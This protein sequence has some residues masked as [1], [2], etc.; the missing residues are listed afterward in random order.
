MKEI[1]FHSVQRATDDIDSS[2]ELFRV[3]SALVFS[4][5]KDIDIP[6]LWEILWSIDE[7]P[8]EDAAPHQEMVW[9]R[10]C[11]RI[12]SKQPLFISGVA[13]RVLIVAVILLLLFAISAVA[14][15][16]LS[17]KAMI[18]QVAIPIAQNNDTDDFQNRTYSYSEMTELIHALNENDMM[19]DENT[20][21]VQA[22]LSGHGFWEEDVVEQ[23]Y[24]EAFGSEKAYWTLEEDFCYG[25]AMVAIGVWDENPYLV[26]GKNDMTIKEACDFAAEALKNE[27]GIYLPSETNEDWRISIDFMKT[28]N[29]QTERY[30]PDRAEWRCCYARQSDGMIIYDICFDRNE[31][32]VIPHCWKYPDQKDIPSYS[33]ADSKIAAF[34]DT[35]GEI[36]AFWP[37]ERQAEAY[38]GW[39]SV[40]SSEEKERIRNLA[41]NAVEEQFGQ[42][43]LEQ[44]GDYRTGIEFGKQPFGESE[45]I[46]ATVYFTTDPVYLSDG[47]RIVIELIDG[48]SLEIDTYYA[49]EGN[50]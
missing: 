11:S 24:I 49:N 25:Q 10:I 48:T 9:C 7:R 14:M 32:W 4:R 42:N 12:Q 3:F 39:L 21:I 37:A 26:P 19:L 6:L 16:L 8:D 18:E 22:F 47:F 20:K 28:F 44:L 1:S 34:I 38:P 43:A 50:G 33:D 23:I 17:P 29:I 35:Y 15:T 2:G 36:V 41:V 13:K 27:Y 40:P 46:H 30:D 45:S 5:A 31:E